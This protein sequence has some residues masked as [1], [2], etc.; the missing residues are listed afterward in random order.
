MRQPSLRPRP[1]IMRRIIPARNLVREKDSAMTKSQPLPYLQPM[2]ATCMLFQTLY[3]LCVALWFVMPDL[4]GHALLPD[5]IPQFKLL[6]VPSFFYGLIMAAMYGW[7]VS[8]VF[9]FFYNLWPSF[10]RLIYGS[11]TRTA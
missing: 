3:V 5:F 7:L 10:A 11:S 8:V 4:S 1:T 6:D 2:F 9:V